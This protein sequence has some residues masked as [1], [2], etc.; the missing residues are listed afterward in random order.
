MTPLILII[1]F[2]VALWQVNK[3]DK[4]MKKEVAERKMRDDE[5]NN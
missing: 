3:W 4:Q 1:L 2:F 5:K